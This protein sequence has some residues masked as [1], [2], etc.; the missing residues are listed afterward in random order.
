MSLSV[1]LQWRFNIFLYRTLGWG[2]ARRLIFSLG[3]LHLL[4]AGRGDRHRIEAAVAE[5]LGRGKDDPRI[6]RIVKGIFS[7]ILSHYYEK[8][9]IA[10]ESVG[11]ATRFLYDAV[12][13]DDL[14]VLRDALASGEGV[15]LVT[16]HYGAIEY[17]PTLLAV[18]RLP[19]T[20][21]AKFK[22]VRLRDQVFEQARKYGIR[23]ID[24][25]RTENVM[26]RGIREL[27]EGRILVTEC[28]EIEEWRPSRRQGVSFLGRVTGMDRTLNILQRRSGARVVFGVIHRYSLT[29]Y[30]LFMYNE[31]Q[32]LR[33]LDVDASP[34]VGETVLKFLEMKIYR[35]PEQW[36][37][38][39]KYFDIPPLT[40]TVI[41]I[42]HAAAV[43]VMGAALQK[44]A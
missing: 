1:F 37:E 24:A 39:K 29:R 10:F 14:E 6:R 30:R 4:W 43:P 9:F 40:G 11:R 16:G 32:M 41:G 25:G 23:L 17:I 33:Q 8:L 26:G 13:S 34:S 28:D 7:G 21:I 12:R 35:H 42:R 19:V 3:R 44:A 18:H 5:V 20:M 36:Y 38:W 22:T 15:I 31:K 27:K 2:L